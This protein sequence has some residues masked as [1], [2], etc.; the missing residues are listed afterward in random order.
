MI[1]SAILA[2]GAQFNPG[3]LLMVWFPHFAL[4]YA[5]YDYGAKTLESAWNGVS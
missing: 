4:A 5:G 3:R 1:V 2:D